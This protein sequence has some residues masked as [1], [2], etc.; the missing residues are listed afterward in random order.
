MST[1]LLVD[2]HAVLRSGVA[3][4][5]KASF[6]DATLG[7]AGNADEQKDHQNHQDNHDAFLTG[8]GPCIILYAER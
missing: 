1:F 8:K 7:E 2:D 4:M 5:L 3:R 6:P